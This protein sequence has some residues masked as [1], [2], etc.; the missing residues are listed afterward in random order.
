MTNNDWLKSEIARLEAALRKQVERAEQNEAAAQELERLRAQKPYR[1]EVGGR[2]FRELNMAQFHAKNNNL[3]S[4]KITPVYSEFRPSAPLPRPNKL[5]A[6]TA[7]SP[8]EARVEFPNCN[9]PSTACY[10][11]NRNGRVCVRSISEIRND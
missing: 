1:W 2:F 11:Q 7:K 3:S 8:P 9:C 5:G 10:G 6:F 4:D